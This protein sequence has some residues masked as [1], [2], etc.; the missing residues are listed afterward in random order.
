MSNGSKHGDR[1]K[2]EFVRWEKRR[3]KVKPFAKSQTPAQEKRV[4]LEAK[5]IT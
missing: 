1:V 2:R 4:F 5:W 3:R